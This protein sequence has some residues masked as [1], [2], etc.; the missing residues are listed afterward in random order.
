MRCYNCDVQY[1]KR[2]GLL[3]FNNKH[4]GIFSVDITDYKECPM[5]GKQLLKKAQAETVEVEA[6]RILNSFISKLDIADFVF[7]SEAQ[8]ILGCSRQAFHK[9]KRIKNGFIHSYKIGDRRVYHKKSVELFKETGDGRFPLYKKTTTTITQL[10]ENELTEVV[11]QTSF[12]VLND[13]AGSEGFFLDTGSKPVQL[14][15][16]DDFTKQTKIQYL[17]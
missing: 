3:T 9:N 15:N 8:T 4:I 14:V 1:E 11:Q 2:S 6:S 17:R 5:C 7:A 10:Y 16:P 13:Q 12:V